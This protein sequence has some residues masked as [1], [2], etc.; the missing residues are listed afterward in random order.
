MRKRRRTP[1]EKKVLSYR[2][3]RRN[4]YGQSDKASRKAIPRHKRLAARSL[5][6]TAKMALTATSDVSIAPT[7]PS[8]REGWKKHPDRPL[9][10][11]LD[12]AYDYGRDGLDRR[13]ED[14]RGL[15]AEARRR[16]KRT[17]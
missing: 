6:R 4:A 7:E 3:D 10:E 14:K 17:R 8:R 16:L 11:H 9:A 1:Q 5:R 2:K 12:D 13:R 15:R